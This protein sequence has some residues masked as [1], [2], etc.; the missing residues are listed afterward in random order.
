[1]RNKR[2]LYLVALGFLSFGA[3]TGCKK[4]SATPDEPETPPVVTT[5][6]GTRDELTKDSIFL[7]GKELYYWNTSLP[8][9]AA[10]NPRGFS[11]NEAELYAMTQYSLD[12]ATGKPYEYVSTSGEPKYSFFDYTAATAGKTGALKADV[13]G[14][15][16]DY[17]FSVQYNYNS[18]TDLRVKYVYPSSSAALQGLTRGCRI[19]SVNGRTDLTYPGAI[20]FLN[21]AIFGT[22]ATVTLA[23]NDIG[24]NP[25]TAVV[26]RSLYTINPILFTNV[27]TVGTKKVGYIVFNSFTNNASSAIN[28]VFSNFATQGVSELVIDLRYNGGGYVSTATEMINLV[29]PAGETG[30]TMFTSYYNNYLQ[31]ITTAQ[32][33]ASVLAHQPL[34]D[35]AGKL[36]TFT[37]G[38]NGKY[39]TYADLNYSPTAADNIEKFAKSGSLT[40]N[41]VYFIVT[42]S[43]ASASELTINS[44]KP[45]M[46]VKLIG[47][48]TYG[49]PVGFF[50]IR[51]DKVDMYIPEFETKNKIGAGGYYSG[52]T[53]DKESPEDLSKAWGDETETLLAYALLYAKNGNFV[54]TA[55]KTASLN[56]ST[57]AVPKLSIAELRELDEKLDPKGFKGMVMTPHKKF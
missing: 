10:F 38:V 51:I 41:R 22:N 5:P 40:L 14:S 17:G 18:T 43:T 3:T 4:S 37:S 36:Q 57:T 21:N 33:R 53:V 56:T 44:L 8:T 31:S 32:R 20:N 11:S 48:T 54:T 28:A 35:D 26:S 42:G 52:L 19:T 34:L 15:A 47:R 16:N 29:A 55:T 13:N 39:A 27:Y 30:N 50:P 9:Y 12:P 7:Y 25:K 49:K 45:V 1:M 2:F 6:S 46:D 23:F 24:G